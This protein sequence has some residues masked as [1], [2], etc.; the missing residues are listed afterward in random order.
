MII[1]TLKAIIGTAEVD[2]VWLSEVM[3]QTSRCFSKLRMRLLMNADEK[4]FWTDWSNTFEE[5]NLYGRYRGAASL[6]LFLLL[7]VFE[8]ATSWNSKKSCEIRLKKTNILKPNILILMFLDGTRES[9]DTL[10]VVTSYRLSVWLKLFPHIMYRFNFRVVTS[11]SVLPRNESRLL[12][13]GRHGLAD[14][15]HFTVAHVCILTQG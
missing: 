14:P 11:G 15:Q 5:V 4:Y 13:T 10:R 2:V 1:K 12:S 9:D 7:I 3:C 8:L 6:F